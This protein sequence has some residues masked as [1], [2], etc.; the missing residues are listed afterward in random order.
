MH[1]PASPTNALPQLAF[2]DS[3]QLFLNDEEL[4]LDI[5]RRSY[6]TDIYIHFR[7]ANVLHL[8]DTSST[9]FIRLS[10]PAQAAISTHDRRHRESIE[11]RH[12]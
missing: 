4:L 3:F 6:D 2:K 8:G 11:A 12:F 5:F 7:K 10:M 1:F 9:G